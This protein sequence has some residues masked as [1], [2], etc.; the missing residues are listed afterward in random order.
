MTDL[1]HIFWLGGGPC[2]GKTTVSDVIGKEHNVSI[3]HVDQRRDELHA[4]ADSKRHP[5]TIEL[6]T[7][8]R[9]EGWQAV[10]GQAFSLPV[11]ESIEMLKTYFR[12]ETDLAI[13]VL[14]SLPA[15]RPILV[16]ST[17]VLPEFAKEICGQDNAFFLLATDDV[18]R[19]RNRKRHAENN[20]M[21]GFT[22]PPELI[23]KQERSFIARTNYIR[24]TAQEHGYFALE[25]DGQLSPQQ[26][27][28]LVVEHFGF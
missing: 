22:W 11:N 17:H 13:Q 5:K 1:S 25:I 21:L 2:S 28:I 12:E 6:S 20:S 4:L 14:K 23:E 26:V 16:D 15:D 3:Y 8:V 9:D 19:R 24:R 7:R 18:I 27:E 10:V